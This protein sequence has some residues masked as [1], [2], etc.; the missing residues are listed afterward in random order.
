[1]PHPK[2]AEWEATQEAFEAAVLAVETAA[3][4]LHRVAAL[5]GP[6]VVVSPTVR[7]HHARVQTVSIPT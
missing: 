1:M 6:T 3:K 5:E 4:N 7:Q 2:E